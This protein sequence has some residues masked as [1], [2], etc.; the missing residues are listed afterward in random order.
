M[1]EWFSIEVFDG[2]VSAR[3]WR[4]SHGDPIIGAAHAERVTDWIWHEFEWGMVLELELPDEFAWQRL[5]ESPAVRAALDAAPAR[6][7]LHRGRGG[8]SGPRAPRRPRPFAGAGA[9]ALLPPPTLEPEASQRP[10]LVSH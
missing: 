5:F 6:Y 1:P 9:V 2:D 4:E 8:S 7:V 10:L 3:A